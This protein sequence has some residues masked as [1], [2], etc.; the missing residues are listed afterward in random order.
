MSGNQGTRQSLPDRVGRWSSQGV[1]R[2]QRR[3]VGTLTVLQEGGEQQGGREATREEV[4]QGSRA[5]MREASE[6]LGLDPVPGGATKYLKEE[7]G[8]TAHVF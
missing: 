7:G 2:A 4:A 5:Q 8:Q 3:E 1:Q 6:E